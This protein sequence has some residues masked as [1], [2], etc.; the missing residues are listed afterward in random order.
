MS[1]CAL[2][3]FLTPISMLSKSMKTAIL[4]R[5]S[6]M[7]NCWLSRDLDLDQVDARCGRLAADRRRLDLVEDVEALDHPAEDGV[8]TVERGRVSRDYEERG[9]GAG[10]IVAARHGHDAFDVLRAVELRLKVV[11]ELLLFFGK[12][13][14]AVERARLDDE[15]AHDAMECG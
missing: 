4:R 6:G 7:C 8:F 11:D 2:R 9:G 15:A 14:A 10:G 5:C 1:N 12:R 13:T 3:V